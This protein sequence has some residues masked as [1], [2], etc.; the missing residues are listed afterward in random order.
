MNL[1]SQIVGILE[2][3]EIICE[4]PRRR[5][6]DDIVYFIP[7][8]V[9]EDRPEEVAKCWNQKQALCKEVSYDNCVY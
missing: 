2:Y 6:S 1:T 8:F 3:F 4:L 9:P 7:W 5:A